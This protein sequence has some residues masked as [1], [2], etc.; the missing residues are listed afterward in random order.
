[1]HAL[2]S[3]KFTFSL[4]YTLAHPFGCMLFE[5]NFAEHHSSHTESALDI[6]TTQN[7]YQCIILHLYFVA[8]L[9]KLM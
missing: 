2:A 8:R 1:M 5:L 4:K 3:G 6:L 7:E 9:N